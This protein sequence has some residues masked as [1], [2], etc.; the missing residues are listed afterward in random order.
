MA[1]MV[2]CP[3]RMCGRTTVLGE[4]PLGRIFRCPRCLTKLPAAG[5]GASDSGWT[6]VLGPLPRRWSPVA[7]RGAATDP[8]GDAAGARPAPASPGPDSGEFLAFAFGARAEESWTPGPGPGLGHGHGLALE[9]QESGEVY[10]GPLGRDDRDPGRG[11][12]PGRDGSGAIAA[13]PRLGRFELIEV[14]GEGHHATVHRAFDPLLRRQVA[15]K[16]PREEV[17]PSSR[18]VDRFLAEARVLARLRHPRIVPIYEAGREGDR[19]YIAMALVEGQSLAER[20]AAGPVPFATAA[21]VVAELAEALAHAH[22]RGIVHRDVKPANVRIDREGQVYLMDFGIAYHP[23]SGEVPLPPGRIL[24]TP[25]YLAPEQAR[26]GQDGALPASDQYS[27]GAVLYELLCGRPPFH[28]P[29]T[30]VLFHAIHHQPPSARTVAPEV[31]RALASICQKAMAKR[32]ERRYPSCR[33]LAADLRRWIGGGPPP[34]RRRWAGL[35]G[36]N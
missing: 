3:N 6:T 28:G 4:D 14:L 12:D 30:Y 17:A 7:R 27:L 19:P 18:G 29:P 33:A 26:G 36:G 10:I 34:P 20:M 9:L 13:V 8:A 5:A 35:L 2:Q 32:P 11:P 25:A 23:E 16:L 31:P 24:G 22:D 15:L 1:A 21:A